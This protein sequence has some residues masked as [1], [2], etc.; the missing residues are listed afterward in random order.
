MYE[1]IYVY[2][3]FVVY[4]KFIVIWRGIILYRIFEVIGKI[5]FD[6]F[7]DNSWEWYEENLMSSKFILIYGIILY[8]R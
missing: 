4:F 2:N 5:F 3:I 6:L 7:L 1:Y 8:G